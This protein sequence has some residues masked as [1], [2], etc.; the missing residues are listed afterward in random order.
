MEAEN[1]SRREV[2]KTGKNVLFFVGYLNEAPCSYSINLA[3]NYGELLWSTG[4][5][6]LVF[7]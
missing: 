5:I 1:I 3:S 2:F 4:D 7:A 6:I